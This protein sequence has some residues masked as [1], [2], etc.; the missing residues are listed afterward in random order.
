[1]LL[2]TDRGA[3]AIVVL[4]MTSLEIMNKIESINRQISYFHHLGQVGLLETDKCSDG[5]EGV[6]WVDRGGRSGGT[7]RI[8]D[9]ARRGQP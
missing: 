2:S 7:A 1:M 3:I 4:N 6:R 9:W 8:G 5:M